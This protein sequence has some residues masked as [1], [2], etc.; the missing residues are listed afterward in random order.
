MGYSPPEDGDDYMCISEGEDNSLHSSEAFCV[1][2]SC[3]Y[4]HSCS[5]PVRALCVEA[6]SLLQRPRV[7]DPLL[8]IIPSL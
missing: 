6:G 7:Q 5:I 4:Y 2:L 8:H 1:T 3:S